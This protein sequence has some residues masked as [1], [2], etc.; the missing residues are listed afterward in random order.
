[1]EF[2]FSKT[3][4]DTMGVISCPSR[5]RGVKTGKPEGKE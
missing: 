4:F 5:Q 3:A 2:G 1:M